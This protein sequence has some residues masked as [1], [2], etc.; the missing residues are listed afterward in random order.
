MSRLLLLIN[1]SSRSGADCYKEILKLLRE[2][3]HQVLS[4][5]VE[6]KNTPFPEIIAKYEDQFDV[7]VVGGGDGSVNAILAEAVRI[8]KPVLV[9]PLGTANNLARTLKIPA[10]LKE[11]L[12][13]IDLN[14]VKKIDLG[15]VNKKYF[16]NVAGIGLS[17][18]VNKTAKSDLKRKLGVFAFVLTAF[19]K[20]KSMKPFT[21]DIRCDQKQ[22][23]AKS[24]QV[25]ICNGRHYGSGLVI[26]HNATLEDGKLHCLSTEIKKWWH[27]FFLIPSILRGKYG[28][29][30]DTT[31][32][33]GQR[34]ILKTKRPMDIDL[35]GDIKTQTP[36]EFHVEPEVFSVLVP[37]A[38]A[39]EAT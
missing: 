28:P 38:E 23:R 16:V 20:A 33:S 37:K 30:A 19:T 7:I 35:D 32:L 17:A 10:D 9:I 1:P 29:N 4:D 13:L 22:H 2:K 39:Q 12:K 18:R 14:I 15:V 27:G 3:G 21:V 5:E 8:K 24:W 11:N 34:L 25:S 31:L 26:S 6:L 36:A